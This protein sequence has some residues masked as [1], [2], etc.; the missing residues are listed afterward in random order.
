[1]TAISSQPKYFRIPCEK[2]VTVV[3][4]AICQLADIVGAALTGTFNVVLPDKSISVG[5]DNVGLPATP[6]PFVTV[7][8]FAVPV[9]VLPVKVSAAVCVNIQFVLYAASA[10]N[11]ASFA[12]FQS[13][14]VCIADVTQST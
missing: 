3:S 7:I 10:V 2:S 11:V 5:N 8:S 12:C 6:L 14:C 1:M 9:I 4:T 13:I